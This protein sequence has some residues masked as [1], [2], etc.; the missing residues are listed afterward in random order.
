MLIKCKLLDFKDFELFNGKMS[1]IS[2]RAQHLKKAREI[3]AEK[4]K[5]KK[6]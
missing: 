2:K 6:K 5:A 3:Q 4:L 1:R